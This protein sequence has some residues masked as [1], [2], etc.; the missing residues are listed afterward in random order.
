[1]QGQD[2]EGLLPALD[3]GV[4]DEPGGAL[5]LSRGPPFSAARARLSSISR[6]ASRSSLMTASSP[7]KWPRFL[8]ILRSW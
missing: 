2:A 1:V 6:M 3:D 7:G 5:R 4:F 8:M